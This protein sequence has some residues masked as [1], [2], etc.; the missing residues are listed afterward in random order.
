MPTDSFWY[1]LRKGYELL[2]Q[3]IALLLLLVPN[4]MV[5]S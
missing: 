1:E 5:S 4:N 3:D 2:M